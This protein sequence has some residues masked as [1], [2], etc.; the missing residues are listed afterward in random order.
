MERPWRGAGAAVVTGNHDMVRLALG[1]PSGNR[2]HAD[3][4]DQ[5]DTHVRSRVHVFQVVNELRQVLDGVDVVVRRRADEADAR[6]RVAQEADVLGLTLP[7]GNW[8]P[9]PGLAPCAILIWI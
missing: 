1:H 2:A 8:P 7:P 9:S 6:H 4:G 3:F 5:L